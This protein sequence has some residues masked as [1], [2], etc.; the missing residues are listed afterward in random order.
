MAGEVTLD[1]REGF[2]GEEVVVSAQ[3]MAALRLPGVSTRMQTGLARSLPLADL[4]AGST[5]LHVALPAL[6]L[7]QDV[8]LPPQRPLWVGVSLSRARDALEVQVQE[9]PFGY[10]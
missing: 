6:G 5:T 3:N 10:L 4:P 7:A 2:A 1:L 9:Q 8:A